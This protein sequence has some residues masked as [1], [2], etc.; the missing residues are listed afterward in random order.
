[1]PFAFGFQFSD[2]VPV[3]RPN[4]NYVVFAT[5]TLMTMFSSQVLTVAI[6]IYSMFM[7]QGMMSCF[8]LEIVLLFP[9]LIV[10]GNLFQKDPSIRHLQFCMIA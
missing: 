10:T 8:L 1:M 4:I 3:S 2:Q 7:S 5:L 9:L 6:V